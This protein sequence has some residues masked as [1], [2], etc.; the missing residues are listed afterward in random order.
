MAQGGDAIGGVAVVG[1]AGDERDAAQMV[2]PCEEG[3]ETPTRCLS[4]GGEVEDDG[5]GGEEAQH[6]LRAGTAV[7]GAGGVPGVGQ[8]LAQQNEDRW[9]V[10]EDGDARG[11]RSG[12]GQGCGQEMLLSCGVDVGRGGDHAPDAR[13]TARRGL[14]MSMR[15][16]STPS[17]LVAIAQM[18]YP[19]PRGKH[20]RAR[21]AHPATLTD[22][23]AA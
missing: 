22:Q 19:C 12:E 20:R 17:G 14:E 9:I 8:D 10:V 4:G 2:V 21:R 23:G 1:D 18:G 15:Q 16:G 6:V 13:D 5:G 7:E 11:Q 3:Q